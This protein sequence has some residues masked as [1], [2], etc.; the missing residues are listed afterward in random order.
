MT[1]RRRNLVGLAVTRISETVPQ[2]SHGLLV[3]FLSHFRY[4]GLGALGRKYETWGGTLYY[5]GYDM[6]YG[7]FGV[8]RSVRDEFL[9]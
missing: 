5:D 1:A 9:E 2:S 3:T 4:D 6:L 8:I 7:H